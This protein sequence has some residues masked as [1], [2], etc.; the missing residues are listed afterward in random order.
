MAIPRYEAC[1][2]PLL[3]LAADGEPHRTRDAYEAMA[4]QFELSEADQHEMLPSGKQPLL[5]NRV[6]WALTYLRQAGLLTSP[7]RGLFQISDVGRGLLQEKPDAIVADT[8]ERYPSFRDFRSRTRK[9]SD[10]IQDSA[11]SPATRAT[12]NKAH[13]AATPDEEMEDA[14][15][16]HRAS[17]EAEF[18]EQTKT[19]SP[20]FFEQLV[21][22]VLVGLGY[23]G[24]R[25]DAAHSVG[26]S[27]DEGIDGTIA[28]DPL[29][30][31]VVY[32][33]AKRWA[34]TIGR[35]EIQKFAGALQGQL[36]RK[37]VFLTTADFTAEARK[38]TQA[39]DASIVLIDGQRLAKLMVDQGVGVS[40]A[41][42]YRMH[43][44][45]TDYF[46]EE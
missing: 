45:D 8:L 24:N 15:R 26:R 28:E 13:T 21:V 40:A 32:V 29:G 23:G 17:I 6:A 3:Q 41:G 22:E 4:Q 30:L 31:D 19:V 36:A 2:L 39:I 12:V 14:W 10:E 7:K 38:F 18:L 16:R 33:Q 34:A 11:D 25:A 35:P 9:H 27:G 1:L 43:R 42:E 5:H 46:S 37:G 20:A 44:I